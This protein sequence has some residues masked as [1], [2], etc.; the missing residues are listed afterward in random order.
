MTLIANRTAHR[1]QLM[2]KN[3]T[4]V[5]LTIHPGDASAEA[6]GLIRLFI[7]EY[8]D[9]EL[10]VYTLVEGHSQ[11]QGVMLAVGEFVAAVGLGVIADRLMRGKVHKSDPM[12]SVMRNA[13]P[14]VSSRAANQLRRLVEANM[15][16]VP[17]G[18]ANLQ[19][20]LIFVEPLYL[21]H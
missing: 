12:A 16:D 6:N 13:I 21:T 20:T 9:G 19:G 18:Y 8:D 15:P 3:G 17:L 4:P 1:V 10:C 2:H 11:T 14:D 7:G 5:Q